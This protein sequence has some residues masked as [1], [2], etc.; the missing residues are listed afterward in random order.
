NDEV[1]L[2]CGSKPKS[3]LM[4]RTRKFHRTVAYAQDFEAVIRKSIE[5]Q[6]NFE[7]IHSPGSYICQVLSA[8]PSWPSL[9]RLQNQTLDCLIESIQK[10]DRR[11]GVSLM[12]LFKI[13]KG[14]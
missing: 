4:Q 3:V 1:Q 12:D 5:D 13:V 6:I 8:K 2:Y 9:Q 7:T 10:P 14:I 11:I